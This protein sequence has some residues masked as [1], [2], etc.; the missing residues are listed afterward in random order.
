MREDVAYKLNALDGLSD[1]SCKYWTILMLAKDVLSEEHHDPCILS[2]TCWTVD[3]LARILKG[4][5]K[6]K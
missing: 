2:F 5:S 6:E 4:I 1:S 3:V